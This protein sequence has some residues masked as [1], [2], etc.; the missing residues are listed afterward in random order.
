MERQSF[1]RLVTGVEEGDH[2]LRAAKMTPGGLDEIALPPRLL[3]GH[4]RTAAALVER[5]GSGALSRRFNRVLAGAIG[6]VAHVTDP[7]SARVA[8]S[9]SRV[10]PICSEIS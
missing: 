9:A 6:R 10:R 1:E 7:G 2:R 8:P 5:H 4:R 3:G